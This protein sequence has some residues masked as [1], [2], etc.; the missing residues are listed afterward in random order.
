MNKS[1]TTH[2]VVAHHDNNKLAMWLFLGG[3]I[4]FFVTL[5]LTYALFRLEQP[6]DYL[7][8]SSHLSIPL[9]GLNTFILI[10]SSYMVVRSLESIQ[11]GDQKGL[12]NYLTAVLVLGALFLIGQAFEWFTLFREGI[13]VTDTFG[14]PF[15]AITGIHGLHVFTGIMWGSLVLAGAYRGAYSRH[16]HQTV[17]LFGLYWHFVDIVWIVLFTLFYL[18]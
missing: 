6:G 17:E 10:T 8:F 1:N 12:R 15:F 11:S 14:T 16:D 4:V 18:L 3:E 2:T 9:I 7:D 5:I 13:S